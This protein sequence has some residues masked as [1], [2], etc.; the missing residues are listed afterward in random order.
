M[1][2]L[3][4]CFILIF[5][6]LSLLYPAKALAEEGTKLP[7]GISRDQIS[8]KIQDFVKEHEK[9][10]AGMATEPAACKS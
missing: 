8:Q 4:L 1:K 6:T 5:L 3:T 7:S 9:T 10:T 2:K